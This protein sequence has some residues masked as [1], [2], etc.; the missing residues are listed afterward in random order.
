MFTLEFY[1]AYDKVKAA[2][3]TEHYDELGYAWLTLP[4]PGRIHELNVKS[5][6]KI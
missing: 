3:P 2:V 6:V 5:H 1:T 4:P